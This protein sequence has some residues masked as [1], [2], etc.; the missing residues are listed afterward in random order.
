MFATL[1]VSCAL[2]LYTDIKVRQFFP[3]LTDEPRELE[4]LDSFLRQGTGVSTWRKG[5]KMLVHVLVD[6]KIFLQRANMDNTL[7][8]MRFTL[9]RKAWNLLW[10]ARGLNNF[11][12]WVWGFSCLKASTSSSSSV[13]AKCAASAEDVESAKSMVERARDQFKACDDYKYGT[14]TWFKVWCSLILKS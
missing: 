12:V 4:Q 8:G 1:F 7:Q 5:E 9:P 13:C 10:R 14:W 3:S 11:E 2:A 6:F